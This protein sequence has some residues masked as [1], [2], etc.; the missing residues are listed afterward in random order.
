MNFGNTASSQR[1]YVAVP[2]SFDVVFAS[3]VDDIARCFAAIRNTLSLKKFTHE[4]TIT[5]IDLNGRNVPEEDLVFGDYSVPELPG[6]TG[7]TSSFW[8]KDFLLD[9]SLQQWSHG[10]NCYVH[11]SERT[12]STLFH[13]RQ[14]ISNYYQALC[15]IAECCRATSGY[16][17]ADIAALPVPPEKLI[18]LIRNCAQHPVYL[19]LIHQDEISKGD[20]KFIAGD[21]HR[22]RNMGAYWLLEWDTYRNMYSGKLWRP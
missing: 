1:L 17:G 3:T 9:V 18:E 19:A 15:D 20:L 21:D 10:I 2:Q 5:R 11:I 8:C 13:S 12:L 14:L 6:W 7:L 16:G 22:I 4:V